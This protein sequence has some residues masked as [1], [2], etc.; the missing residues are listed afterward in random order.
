[1]SAPNLHVSDAAEQ[2]LRE[3]AQQTNQ[4]PA[5]VFDRAL[6]A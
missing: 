5:E 6:D 2:L 1:M 3:L 4:T